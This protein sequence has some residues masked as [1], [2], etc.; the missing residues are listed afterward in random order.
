M[1]RWWAGKRRRMGATGKA[2]EWRCQ[3]HAG[4]QLLT[5]AHRIKQLVS[6]R[7][8]LLVG[9]K[10]HPGLIL[11]EQLLDIT[12]ECKGQR[13]V[14]RQVNEVHPTPHAHPTPSIHH[15]KL[16]THLRMVATRNFWVLE[17]LPLLSCSRCCSTSLRLKACSSIIR[18]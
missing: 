5:V 9:A 14:S 12:A 11:L 2:R 15:R 6:D 17:F 3:Y 8:L 4:Q 13:K 18:S 10:H 1:C 7:C 16:N